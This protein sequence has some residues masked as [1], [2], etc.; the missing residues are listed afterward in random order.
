MGRHGR[1]SCVFMLVKG[2]SASTEN[3]LRSKRWVMRPILLMDQVVVTHGKNV[4]MLVNRIREAG[5]SI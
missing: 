3:G 4:R 2:E 1:I 5:I